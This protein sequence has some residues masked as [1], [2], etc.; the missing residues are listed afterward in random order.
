MDVN[1]GYTFIMEYM[2][3]QRKAQ[4]KVNSGNLKKFT[5]FW[6]VLQLR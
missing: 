4:I 6:Y 3:S 5:A 2:I 1:S